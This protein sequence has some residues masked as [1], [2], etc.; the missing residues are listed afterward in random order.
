MTKLAKVTTKSKLEEA[1]RLAEEKVFAEL[2]TQQEIEIDENFKREAFMAIGMIAAVPAIVKSINAHLGSKHILAL[3]EFQERKLYKGFGHDNFADFLT[4]S[5]HSPMTKNQYFDRLNLMLKEGEETYDLLN[6]LGVSNRDRKRLPP[7]SVR[8]VGD[9]ILVNDHAVP[10]GNNS[11][12]KAVVND[13]IRNWSEAERNS[14]QLVEEK[15]QTAAQVEKLKQRISQGQ[16]EFD[17]LRRSMDAA[18]EGTPYERALTKAVGALINLALEANKATIIERD[19]RGKSDLQSLWEQMKLVRHALYQDDF[20]FTDDVNT[21]NV[22]ISNLAKKV[23]AADDD[24]GDED[25]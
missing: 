23:F 6:E 19:K 18:S 12:A 24:F 9:E 14:K 11:E 5:P 1:K 13:L 25:E 2:D 16:E 20:V 8:I 17:E 15:E 22:E 3:R 21:G 7:A 4:N 10:I